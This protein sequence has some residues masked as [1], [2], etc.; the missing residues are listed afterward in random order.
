MTDPWQPLRESARDA[1][2]LTELPSL[3]QE[4][5]AMLAA[6]PLRHG[7]I[8]VAVKGDELGA[9]WFLL[10]GDHQALSEV[11]ELARAFVG[12]TS[13]RGRRPEAHITDGDP[14]SEAVREFAPGGAFVLMS[15]PTH[16]ARCAASL[17]LMLEVLRRRPPA[18]AAA[19]RHIAV[20]L[21]D[22]EDAAARENPSL[23][24]QLAEEAWATGRISLV[25]R[26]FLQ[27]RLL[28]CERLWSAVLD[29]AQQ[30]RLGDLELPRSV[31]HDLV[32]SSYM[33]ALQEPLL[34]QGPEEAVNAFRNEVEPTIGDVFRDP[35]AATSPEA[36]RAW[37]IRYAALD[38][39]MPLAARTELLARADAEEAPELERIAGLARFDA[40]PT[41]DTARE[42]L[43][44]HEDAAAWSLAE[45][46]GGQL[47]EPGR[48]GILV[49][50][51]GR[52]DDPARVAVATNA[53]ISAEDQR[54]IA[55]PGKLIEALAEADPQ[56]TVDSWEEWLRVLYGNPSWTDA[57]AVM[58][59]GS[60]R[61]TDG[62]RGDDR[63]FADLGDLVEVL[64]GEA[65][66]RLAY[67]RL[68]RALIPT[69]ADRA[70]VAAGRRSVL[71]ALLKSAAD[72]PESGVADLD[73]AADIVSALLDG[74]V[75][76]SAYDEAVDALARLWARGSGAPR[77]WRWAVDI[78]RILLTHAVPSE[79]SRYAAIGRI[80]G[81]LTS[82]IGSA[83]R[84][85]PREV[86]L[87]MRELLR[88]SELA[89]VIPAPPALSDNELVLEEFGHLV[90]KT[91]L[92]HTLVPSVAQRA[93][94]YLE[95]AASKLTVV[96]D[97]SEQGNPRLREHARN[98]D[99]IVVASRACKHAASDFIR[100]NASG[101][102][103]WAS[104]KGWSSLV[105]ALRVSPQLA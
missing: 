64:S 12:S 96:S 98:A 18:A 80:A 10:G 9:V 73:A 50:A 45:A 79:S 59:N 63:S 6:G 32:R 58:E 47:D 102:V 3:T 11:S 37:M 78:T 93:A 30:H 105:D 88:D 104:G 74:G 7:Q 71:A 94:E 36:R 27:T 31:E 40:P 29:Y 85:I 60:A 99:Y 5:E 13:A 91:V 101:E 4:I 42:L 92:L 100:A 24:R 54:A 43:N 28:A 68:V 19:A 57:V 72:D 65:A 69:G 87:E 70:D 38:R 35:R 75:S 14:F 39:S 44:N 46:G 82:D 66:F 62:M 2:S 53:V 17:Q 21:R 67:P 25:N 49:Q 16:A 20:V 41:D 81:P 26:S 56:P 89:D 1:E 97:N 103:K 34:R 76:A 8:G 52:L 86:I 48:I 15:P 77:L 22:F 95:M 33:A 83:R 51:A 61:W 23:A 90:G 84:F 55:A